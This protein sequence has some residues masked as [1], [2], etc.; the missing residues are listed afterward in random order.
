MKRLILASLTALGCV[1]FVCTAG[2]VTLDPKTFRHTVSM[3]VV[4]SVDGTLADFPLLVRIDE[5]H[6]KGWKGN[7]SPDGSDLR[8][9]DAHGTL[10]AHEIDTWTTDESGAASGIVWVK[11][12]ELKTGTI[13][14]MCWGADPATLP[15]VDSTDVWT[16]Y[17]GVWHFGES[18]GAIKDSTANHLDL[19][20]TSGTMS[21]AG[22][23]CIGGATLAGPNTEFESVQALVA[24]STTN[25]GSQ[26]TFSGFFKHS[27]SDRYYPYFVRTKTS[28]EDT[29][30]GF[31]TGFYN[32][33]SIFFVGGSDTDAANRVGEIPAVNAN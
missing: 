16:E 4:G 31:C 9:A 27:G 8:F 11:V 26:C 1:V 2:G 3:A 7:A 22:E 24:G 12:P 28:H 5:D 10:L 32:Y 6:V 20:L 25:H 18:A 29:N 21:A 30:G 23:S 33:E 17:L 14:Q 13:L 19:Q 15:A